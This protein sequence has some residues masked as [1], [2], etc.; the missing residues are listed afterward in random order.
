MAMIRVAYHLTEQQ[1]KTLKD[2]SEASGIPVS[3]LIRRAV[4]LYL[5]AEK[6]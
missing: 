3:E 4:D 2:Q 5:K 1:L 6:K